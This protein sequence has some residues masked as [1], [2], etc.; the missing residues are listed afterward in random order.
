[1][2][3]GC[4]FHVL[5]AGTNLQRETFLLRGKLSMSMKI[6]TIGGIALALAVG[7][8]L[9]RL[10]PDS[11]SADSSEAA[12]KINLLAH[13][14]SLATATRALTYLDADDPDGVRV[15]MEEQLRSSL[16]I[17]EATTPNVSMSPNEAGLVER[18]IQGGKRYRKI[19][20]E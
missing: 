13:A 15:L 3:G 20:S 11:K 1:M 12:L 10:A 8:G 9:G 16:T 6:S 7:F 17:L 4:R 2:Y 18:A 5:G 14:N 19:R